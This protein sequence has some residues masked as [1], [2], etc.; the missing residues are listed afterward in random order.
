MDTPAIT[1]L[2][3]A[4]FAHVLYVPLEAPHY[5][6]M[7]GS[8]WLFV[9]LS[10]S[11]RTSQNTTPELGDPRVH[12]FR[13]ERW[14]LLT[15]SPFVLASVV[16][17]AVNRLRWTEQMGLYFL[18]G[19]GAVYLVCSAFYHRETDSILP[20]EIAY[21]LFAGGLA[22]LFL[23]ANGIFPPS[24]VSGIIVLLVV[25]L[26]L[27]FWTSSTLEW[28]TRIKDRKPFPLRIPLVELKVT[29]L[30]GF[31]ALLAI[32]LAPLAINV[33]LAPIFI[34][35]AAAATNLCL[36]AWFGRVISGIS[37]RSA[38]RLMLLTPLVPLGL[39]WSGY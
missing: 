5:L 39:A 18:A 20:R 35:I 11:I 30:N 8:T 6:I 27:A 28:A 7:A 17:I 38:S 10:R 34:A 29:W 21:S 1:V 9:A 14:P 3:L 33:P 25:L 16:I 4:L 26:I 2:W 15:V 36:L 12:F 19:A 13:A 23:L 32:A 31:V 37:A 22:S 24:F